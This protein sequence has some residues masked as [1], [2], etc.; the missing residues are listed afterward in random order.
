MKKKTCNKC[1]DEKPATGEYFRKRKPGKYV[2]EDGL[3]GQCKEC[4]S[5]QRKQHYEENRERLIKTAKEWNNNNKERV[6]ENHREY[7]KNNRE[8][9]NAYAIE[10]ANNEEN[11]DRIKEYRN[12]YSKTWRSNNKDKIKKYLEANKEKTRS[13]SLIGTQKRNALKRKLPATLTI[14]QWEQ[15][16]KDFNHQCCYCGKKTTLEQEHFIP[17]ASSGG[18]TKENIIPACK[19]CNRSKGK[20]D[21]FD[22]YPFQE[23]YSQEREVIIVEYLINQQN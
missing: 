5:K 13:Y 18:Y 14:D 11:R 10:W 1:G 4:E 9:L 12:K 19:R 23:C 16:K 20:K 17:V 15:I 2:N 8:K 3:N 6:K 21:F 7:L 22:W